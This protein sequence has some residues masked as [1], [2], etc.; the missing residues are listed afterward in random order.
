ML[1]IAPLL[2][3]DPLSQA[4]RDAL[5]E[6][7]QKIQDTAD[8]KTDARY[9]MAVA[10]FKAAVGSD[11]AALELYL[12]CVEKQQVEEQGKKPQ[13]F[14]EWKRKQEA[15]LSDAGFHQ[16]LRLQLHWLLLTLQAASTKKE[17]TTFGPEVTRVMDEI[18]GN[19]AKLADQR[20]VLR[21][22]VL[23]SIFAQTYGVDSV[24]VK[25]WPTAPLDTNGIFERVV[26]P[27]LRHADKIDGLRAA[28]AKR[29]QQEGIAAAQWA[30]DPGAAEKFQQ[31]TYPEL[32]W[33]M[34]MDAYRSGDQRNAA[35]H[36]FQ[37][38]EKFAAHA[39]APDWAKQFRD[40]LT[41]KE[42][43]TKPDATKAT[44]GKAADNAFGKPVDP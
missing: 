13:E 12:K 3:A 14:R 10:A 26:M 29:I 24:T 18:Y 36:M 2:H 23:G 4:D 19:A 11:Q 21:Q 43:A 30:K 44:A 39:K 22:S 37:H 25:D 32:V 5:L 40:L 20:N 15:Q 8:A 35:L 1:A 41:P 17:I 31:E 27:P 33:Q 7:L 16:A 34:E 9:A 28:W 42:D 6:K 38:L